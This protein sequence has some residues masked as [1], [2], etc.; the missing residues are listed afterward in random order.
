MSV[1]F[2]WISIKANYFN[3]HTE[4][5]C[6]YK[7]DFC[8]NQLKQRTLTCPS[9][10]LKHLAQR[11]KVNRMLLF[12]LLAFIICYTPFTMVII[13]RN[14]VVVSTS[15]NSVCDIIKILNKK[16]DKLSTE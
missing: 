7:V 11:K 1:V 10:Q 3:F 9:A 4:Y 15:I 16:S 6:Y 12:I 14:K 5:Y 8:S 13:V 2:S